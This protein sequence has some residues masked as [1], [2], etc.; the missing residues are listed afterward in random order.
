MEV[1]GTILH[2]VDNEVRTIHCQKVSSHGSHIRERML[3]EKQAEAV[4][5]FLKVW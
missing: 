3:S 5:Y 2:S 1:S 4:L